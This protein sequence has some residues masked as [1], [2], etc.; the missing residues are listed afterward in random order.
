MEAHKYTKRRLTYLNA[1][2]TMKCFSVINNGDLTAKRKFLYKV[3]NQNI[4]HMHTKWQ[5]ENIKIDATCKE[6]LL[7]LKFRLRMTDSI[8]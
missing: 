6:D 4:R 2:L 7:D 3:I 1:D 8:T 5:S